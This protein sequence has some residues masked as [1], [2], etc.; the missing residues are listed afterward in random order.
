MRGTEF[1]V[2]MFGPEDG[3]HVTAAAALLASAFPQ[4]YADCAAEEVTQILAPERIA[5]KAVAG[6]ELIGF[7]GAIPQYGATGW[8]LHPVVVDARHRSRGVG[9]ALVRKIE[10]LCSA[11]GAA[12]LYLGTDDEFGLTSLSGCDLY[13]DLYGRIAG[14]QNLRAHPYEFYQKLGYRIV[15]VIPD[16]NGFG[17][18]DIIMAKRIG[19]TDR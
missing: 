6:G 1:T 9:S 17:K 4:A 12:T 10:R 14:I 2:E 7:A 5:V 3:A 8:E 18:P 16:A 15:G 13:G 11:R 19:G